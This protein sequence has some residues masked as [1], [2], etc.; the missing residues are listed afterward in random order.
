L[1]HEVLVI[2][3][4]TGFKRNKINKVVT[5]VFVMIVK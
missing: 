5:Q 4:K 2:I 3:Q 1:H